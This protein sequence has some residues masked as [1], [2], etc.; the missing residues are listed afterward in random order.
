MKK[1]ERNVSWRLSAFYVAAFLFIVILIVRLVGI[2]LVDREK[3][4]MKAHKQYKYE[5]KLAPE[6]G[7]ILDRKRELLAFNVPTISVT[8][9]PQRGGESVQSSR[10]VGKCI[11]HEY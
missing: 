1:N 10:A 9:N 8:A 5:V 7:K 3:F 2:Q 4:E 11:K 6:R